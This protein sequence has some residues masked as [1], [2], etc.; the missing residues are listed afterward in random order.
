VNESEYLNVGEMYYCV[1]SNDI[2]PLIEL[3]KDWNLD[4]DDIE[5]GAAVQ[6]TA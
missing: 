3:C 2:E 4:S 5:T 1:F 6:Q